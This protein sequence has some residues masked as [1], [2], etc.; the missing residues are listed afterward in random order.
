MRFQEKRHQPERLP[1]VV[2]DDDMLR[3][4]ARPS[5]RTVRLFQREE[6]RVIE[7]RVVRSSPG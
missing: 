2:A 7:E 5:A 6:K 3:L 1:G 4:P